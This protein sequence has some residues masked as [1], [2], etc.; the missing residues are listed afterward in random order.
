M[1]VAHALGAGVSQYFIAGDDPAAELPDGEIIFNAGQQIET[2]PTMMFDYNPTTN[3]ITPMDPSVMPTDLL[4]F[5]KNNADDNTSMLMLPTGQLLMS[6]G[7]NRQLYIYTPSGAG[8]AASSL[9][10]ISG[11]KDNGDGTF[12]LSGTQLNGI[13][14]GAFYGDDEGNSENYPLVQLTAADGSVA[15]ARTFNWSSEGV[16]TGSAPETTQFVLP[17]DTPPGTYQ[18]TVSAAGITSQPFSFTVTPLEATTV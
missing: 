5:L 18:L 4:T 3:T 17:A 16:Q 2:A 11:V 9:Q 13:S 1:A 6:N 7:V 15:Y 8:P 10:T 14:E 12:T